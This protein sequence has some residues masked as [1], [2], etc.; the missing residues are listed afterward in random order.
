MARPNVGFNFIVKY[1][2]IFTIFLISIVLAIGTAAIQ[3]L[4]KRPLIKTPEIFQ[5]APGNNLVVNGGFETEVS[6]GTEL[7]VNG[8]FEN[9]QAGW[10]F[11][12][13]G[14]KEIKA[15]TNPYSGDFSLHLIGASGE[16]AAKA[17]QAV[18]I[19]NNTA[20]LLSMR[21][22]LAGTAKVEEWC[23]GGA[24]DVS[25][26]A[27]TF[28]PAGC[29][30]TATNWSFLSGSCGANQNHVLK[31]SLEASEGQE[32]WAD[33][34]SLKDKKPPVKWEEPAATDFFVDVV[35]NEKYSGQN[36]LRL[37]TKLSD[38]TTIKEYVNKNQWVYLANLH[39][40][41]PYTLAAC[42]KRIGDSHSA[43][44]A[45]EYSSNNTFLVSHAIDFTSAAWE[46]KNISFTSRDEATTIEVSLFLGDNN[47]YTGDDPDPEPATDFYVDDVQLL[48]DSVAVS[49]SP[50]TSEASPSPSSSPSPSVSVSPSPSPGV[51]TCYDF[52]HSGKYDLG[53]L[54]Y[55]LSRWNNVDPLTGVT[56]N[57]SVFMIIL[58]GWNGPC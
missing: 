2:P 11:E 6:S 47:N 55:V 19:N 15:L 29:Y 13:G 20:Y 49:P 57:V 14:L 31:I 33:E 5:Q 7:V 25:Q 8:G 9:S 50:S 32:L 41:S 28:T 1:K 58:G 40:G 53:D 23:L 46:C 10:S 12:G 18:T 39:V 44:L 51:V 45:Q 26:P 27:Q 4:I 16:L 17:S 43:V 42:G 21:L 56:M 24:G 30:T 35:S 3:L 54:L 38:T 52:D 34:I 37:T 48:D 22:C 36:S